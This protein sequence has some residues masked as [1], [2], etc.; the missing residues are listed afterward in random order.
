MELPDPCFFACYQ[1]TKVR[2]CHCKVSLILPGL[3]NYSF[4]YF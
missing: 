4:T 2:Y 3:W 1:R